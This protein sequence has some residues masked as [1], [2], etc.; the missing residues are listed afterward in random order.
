[1]KVGQG[2]AHFIAD[3]HTGVSDDV[4]RERWKAGDYDTPNGGKPRTDYVK[5]WRELA[6][7]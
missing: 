5:G 4:M 7:R 6:G 1:M 2:N 3:L